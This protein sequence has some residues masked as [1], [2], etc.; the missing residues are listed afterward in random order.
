MGIDTDIYLVSVTYD[1]NLRVKNSESVAATAMPSK[2]LDISILAA[3]LLFLS[4]QTMN[5]GRQKNACIT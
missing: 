3:V 5:R 4:N 2:I 1:W